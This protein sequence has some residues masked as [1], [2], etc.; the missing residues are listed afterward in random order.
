V[1][2]FSKAW[3]LERLQLVEVTFQSHSR[4]MAMVLFNRQ[5]LPS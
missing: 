1:S 5:C 4:W 2:S 3:Y